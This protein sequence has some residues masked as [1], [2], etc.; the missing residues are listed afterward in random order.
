MHK[1]KSYRQVSRESHNPQRDQNYDS[2]SQLHLLFL[3]FLVQVSCSSVIGIILN[4]RSV[5]KIC[6]MKYG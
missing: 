1:H 2:C 4:Y 5:Y 6:F 3:W